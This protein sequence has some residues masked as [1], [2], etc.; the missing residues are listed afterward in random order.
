[1]PYDQLLKVTPIVLDYLYS[2]TKVQN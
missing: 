2:S 1:M